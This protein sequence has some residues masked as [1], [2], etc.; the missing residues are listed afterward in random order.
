MNDPSATPSV[1]WT[2]TQGG[3]ACSP[4]CGTI[5]P[6]STASGTPATYTAPAVV[7]NPATVT[8][9]ATSVTDPTKSGS[10]TITVTAAGVNNAE[11]NGQYAF[12][13]TGFDAGG[14]M[15]MA[16]SFIADGA[17]GLNS[18]LQDVNRMSG[19]TM[20]QA[21]TGTYTVGPDNRGSMTLTATVGGTAL[22]TSRFALG[23]FNASNVATK[24]EFIE[25]DTSGTRGS[26]VIG[27]QNPAAF[28]AAAISGAYALGLSGVNSSGLRFGLA[29]RFTAD[30]AGSINSGEVDTDSRT[31]GGGTISSNGSFAGTYS[32]AGT[33]RGTVTV[34]S[35]ATLGPF[36]FYVVSA[37]ELFAISTA[38]QSTSGLS[39]GQILQQSGGPF[40]NAS[41][42]GA[43]VIGLNGL[44]P[45]GNADLIM[46][47]LN[48][49]GAGNFTMT[50][51][52][53]FLGTISGPFS[54]FG[55]YSVAANGRATIQF[56]SFGLSVVGYLV[57]PN[58]GFV[59]GTATDNRITT[60]FFEPQS[61][62]PFNNSSVTGNMFFGSTTPVNANVSD[63]SGVLTFNNGSVTGTSDSSQT[64]GL[65]PDQAFAS[66]Y[67]VTANGRAAIPATG[68]AANVFYIVSPS[69]FI[70]MDNSTQSS[71]QI[72]EK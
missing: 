62:G 44:S 72:I 41:L 33:G 14:S 60:G 55:T 59:V 70:L 13:F 36:S 51:D 8:I 54:D 21:F 47:A 27:M 67:N 20:S 2:L 15:A 38:P 69:K 23:S 4:T 56:T 29:G 39:S 12:L 43:S 16:G 22:G 17:G 5:A 61:A 57:A 24:A 64:S 10:A 7:P 11:L 63:Q 9:T 71:I 19:V 65:F 31:P 18:G 53:S 1:N 34:T 35:G 32:V 49:D 48:A 50:D 42:N 58:K 3:T 45:L 52:E 68:T 40:V 66:T 28:S 25:F 6:T 30:G 26:G 46:G 37:T